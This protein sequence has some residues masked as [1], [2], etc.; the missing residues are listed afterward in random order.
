MFSFAPAATKPENGQKCK[1][2]SH[3]EKARDIA[4]G[5]DGMMVMTVIVVII[6]L[7]LSF[8]FLVIGFPRI[9]GR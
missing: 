6:I 4:L 2:K 9:A 8:V 3:E 5:N 7:A 1:G